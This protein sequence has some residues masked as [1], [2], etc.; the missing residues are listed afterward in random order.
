MDFFEH[1]ESAR[2]QTGRLVVLFVLAVLGI[3]LSVYAVMVLVLGG[4]EVKNPE[5]DAPSPWQWEV[6]LA[7]AFVV[8]LVVGTGSYYKMSQ[9]R[10]GGRAVAEMLR[11]RRIAHGTRDRDERRLV[12][13]IEEMAIASGTPVPGIYVMDGEEGINAFAAGHTPDDAVIGVTKGALEKLSRDE[14]QAVIGHE[15][16]HILHGDMRL[17]LRLMGIVHGILVIGILGYVM[18]RFGRLGRRNPVP[19]IGLALFVIGYLGTF[20]GNLIKA[21]VSRQREF[22]A[23]ASSVQYTR[24]PEGMAGA[25][26]RIRDD[27]R[28]SRMRNAHAPEV[29]HMLFGAVDRKVASLVATHPPLKERIR[30]IEGQAGRFEPGKRRPAKPEPK[31]E[32]AKEAARGLGF[33]AGA[34]VLAE[35]AVPPA[36][37]FVG[38]PSAAHLEYARSLTEALP[39][40]V[41]RAA[42]EPAGA[43]AVVYALLLNEEAEARSFQLD[44]LAQHV[45]AELVKETKTLADAVSQQGR[46]IRL[47][48]ID[49]A[50]PALGEMTAAQFAPFRRTVTALIRADQRID[51]FEWTLGRILL[52]HLEPRFHPVRVPA[53]RYRTWSGLEGACSMLLSVLAHV[54]YDSPDVRRAAF[55]RGAKELG[56]ELRHVPLESES[57][58][59][60]Q[61][62]LDRLQQ[63]APLLKRQLLAAAAATISIDEYVTVEEGE[64]FRAIADSLDCPVP[65]LLPGQSLS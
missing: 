23:D 44:Y 2:R 59:L 13:V 47:P 18:M 48:L 32:K 34:A 12:N 61:Q 40:S 21:A 22:L 4:A 11:G 8:L 20:F 15:F 43:R 65:P 7:C 41:H 63:A 28:G 25:L 45:E 37:A 49:I 16:S 58:P 14:L 24:N 31:R 50:L 64:L 55:A 27:A 3:I 38:E 17:N 39:E 54:G 60:L 62:A 57:L 51:V 30:R 29:S 52:R 26:H 6:L 33:V 56:R 19:V 10:A 5:L 1:Q 46:E 35:S 53:M 42:R 9:L 36:L